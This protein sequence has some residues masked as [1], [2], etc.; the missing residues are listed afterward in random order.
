V[1]ERLTHHATLSSVA[2]GCVI[3]EEEEEEEENFFAKKAGCQRGLQP[4][5]A[6]YLTHN[7]TKIDQIYT[8]VTC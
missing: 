4:I 7:K 3:E 6:G 1:T 5:N 8:N 2:I